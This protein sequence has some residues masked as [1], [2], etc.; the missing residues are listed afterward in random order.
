MVACL[1]VFM[2]VIDNK[3][4]GD[5]DHM[6]K[7]TYTIEIKGRISP[8]LIDPRDG[9]TI[10]TREGLNTLLHLES[11]DQATLFGVL[12]RVRDLGI[13]LISVTTQK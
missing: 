11:V 7:H 4:N 2:M 8:I 9:V 3:T 5:A 12:L 10:E 13:D 6:E 1:R